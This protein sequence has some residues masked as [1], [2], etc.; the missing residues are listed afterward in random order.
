MSETPA[1]APVTPE[2]SQ[3]ETVARLAAEAVVRALPDPTSQDARIAAVED[4][5]KQIL[6]LLTAAAGPEGNAAKLAA[7][8]A[9]VEAAVAALAAAVP[10][11]NH[12]QQLLIDDLRLKVAKL[13]RNNHAAR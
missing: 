2:P 3:L 5:A 9:E 12:E 11:P 8:L 1:E 7:R 13:E 4:Q 6:Q 10:K